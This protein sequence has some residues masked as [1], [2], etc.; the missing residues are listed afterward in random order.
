MSHATVALFVIGIILIIA[1]AE[2]LI[3]GASKLAT[4][5]GISPLV[6]GLTVV[7]FGTSSPELAVSLQ[8]ALG[9]QGELAIGNVVGSNILNILL[10]L[11]L[12]AVIAP[13]AV[14]QK[15]IRLDVPLMIGASVLV[16]TL[17]LDGSIGRADGCLLALLGIIYTLFTVWQSRREGRP[18]RK[19][20]E[21][22]FEQGPER[23][24]FRYVAQHAAFVLA[25]LAVLGLGSHWLVQGAVTVA[26][27]FGVSELIIGLTIIAIGTSLPEIATTVM[28]GVRAERDIAV[29]NAIG[30]NLFNLLIVLGLAAVATPAGLKVPASAR[31]FDL[32]VMITVA[33]ACLPVFFVGGRI[34]RW[35]GA[36][37][38]AYYAAYT[39]YLLM[40]STTHRLLPSYSDAMGYFVLPLTVVTLGILVYRSSRPKLHE[41]TGEPVK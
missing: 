13:L 16:W 5:F 23:Q 36:V 21:E 26:K 32:P 35:E 15:L 1:G 10:V 41:S 2:L 18:V 12:A 24:T 31:S 3:R 28:A 19:T 7:A 37:F 33:V 8:S 4:S 34:A 30:S 6:V 14:S 29:G 25:G 27:A 22:E 38:L 40:S 20:Y 9:G 17:S 39:V 11:G